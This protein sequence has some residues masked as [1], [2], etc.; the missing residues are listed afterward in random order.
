MIARRA[1]I[2]LIILG[3]LLFLAISALLAR[4]LS[5]DGAERSAITALVQDEARGDSTGM[6]SRITGCRAS[7]SCRRRVAANAAALKRPGDVAILELNQSA[8]FSLSSTVG[9]ARVAWRAGESLPIVQCVRVKRAGN[10]L[11][12]LHV[13]LLKISV[14]IKSDRDCPA[15]Y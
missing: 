14:R 3:V 9:T 5:V 4:A 13:E 10:V 12:G 15:R 11:S 8:G 1:R 2:A 7:A 6:Q